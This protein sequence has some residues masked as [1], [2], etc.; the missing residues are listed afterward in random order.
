MYN[1][2][3]VLSSTFVN[4]YYCCYEDELYFVYSYEFILM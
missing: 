4:Y 2:W 3:K 1:A